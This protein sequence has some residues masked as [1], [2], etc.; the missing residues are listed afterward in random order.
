MSAIEHAKIER[1]K[2]L[3]LFGA[4]IAD[5]LRGPLLLVFRLYW[6]WQFFLTGS[7]K[8]MHLD[9]VTE[10]F[11][12]LHI[13]APGMN[14]AMAGMTECVGG[15]LIFLGLGAR[16]AALP[17]TVTMTVAYM[18]ADREAVGALFHG[19]P[20]AFLKAVPFMFLVTSLLV[21]AFG[22]GPFSVDALIARVAGKKPASSSS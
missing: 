10:F 15:L 14:A 18:T 2:K 6:G 3:Y 7:G 8:L 13:P 12:S 21:L 11:A 20:D 9:R 5:Y 17:L 22:A 16:I 1:A 4:G 19:N